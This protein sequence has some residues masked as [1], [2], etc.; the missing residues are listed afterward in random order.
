MIRN[1]KNKPNI[2]IMLLLIFTFTGCEKEVILDLADKTG[3]YIIVEA[4]LTDDGTRQWIRLS[5]SSSYY[6]T[7]RGAPVTGARISID[8]GEKEFIF[9]E[10]MTDSLAGYYFNDRVSNNMT[11]KN[12][13]LT[14]THNEQNYYATSSWKPLPVIDS[15]TMRI[16]AFSQLGFRPDTLYDIVVHFEELTST[17][18]HYLFNL[19]VNDTLLTV[20]PRDKGLVSDINL[21]EYVSFAVQNINK[22]RIRVGD[23]I[24]LEMR[25]I[26]KEN[27]EFYN[28]FFFQTDLSGNPFAGAPPA[29]I[30]TNL[31]KGAK[32]FFQV[33]A[34]QR[35][36]I[37]YDP[38][39]Q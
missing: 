11:N 26:S 36:T 13:E 21:T 1:W 28:V 24:T 4:N 12:L 31:S 5:N 3:A 10:N 18:D 27:F 35:K 25:S 14:I 15:V 23:A 9:F 19:Y 37:I 32:G 17:E 39:A 20:R 34:V 16:N 38:P 22:N 30:P 6:D 29:N 2:T 7:G 33:S 8:N